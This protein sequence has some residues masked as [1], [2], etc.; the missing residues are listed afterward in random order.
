M[1]NRPFAPPGR[2]SRGIA[3]EAPAKAEREAED[4]AREVNLDLLNVEQP[5]G[6][7]TDEDE[8]DLE[9]DRKEHE[10]RRGDPNARPQRKHRPRPEQHPDGGLGEN[11]NVWQRPVPDNPRDPCGDERSEERDRDESEWKPSRPVGGEED[12][13]RRDHEERHAQTKDERLCGQQPDHDS[14]WFTRARRSGRRR[15]RHARAGAPRAP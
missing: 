7:P 3:T 9:Q 6:L 5:P 14:L 13:T 1:R 2:L 4:D 11:R 12:R 8:A 10:H 15:R